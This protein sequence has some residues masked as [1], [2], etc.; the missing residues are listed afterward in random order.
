M[1]RKSHEED[2]ME[3][4]RELL[5]KCNS[6]ADNLT[7]TT[8]VNWTTFAALKQ[9]VTARLRVKRGCHNLPGIL[10]VLDIIQSSG[11][12]VDAGTVRKMTG[13]NKQKVSKILY[14]LFKH[15]EIMIENGGLYAGVKKIAVSPW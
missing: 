13:Y 1:S 7:N 10:F 12:G 3:S 6:Q 8:H 2:D 9:I 15:G 4:G 5:P 14:K 11:A